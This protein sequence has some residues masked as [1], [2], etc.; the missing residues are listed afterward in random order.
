MEENKKIEEEK[1]AVENETTE[2]VDNV[3]AEEAVTENDKQNSKTLSIASL[4]LGIVSLVAMKTGLISL[5]CGILAIIFGVKGRKRAGR[6]MAMAGLIMGIISVAFMALAFVL[7]FIIG[8]GVARFYWNSI[9]IIKQKNKVL[10][11]VFFCKKDYN[12]YIRK[13]RRKFYGNKKRRNLT[14]C[15]TSKFKN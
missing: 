2:V 7:V 10:Y 15:K 12:I 11:L 9:I 3:V 1:L 13:E 6:G 4:V 14:Y 5:T 8:V